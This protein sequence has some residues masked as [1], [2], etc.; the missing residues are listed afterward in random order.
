L[1]LRNSKYDFSDPPITEDS[2]PKGILNYKP[3]KFHGTAL[4]VWHGMQRGDESCWQPQRGLMLVILISVTIT[5]PTDC[6]V[7]GLLW[8][9]PQM[10]K[11]ETQY[12]GFYII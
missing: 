4:A 2:S 1:A 11:S 3:T 7:I 9:G 5:V 10:K 12:S 6:T 8:E